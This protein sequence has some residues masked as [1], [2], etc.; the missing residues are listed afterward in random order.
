MYVPFK[1]RVAY[2][3]Q[4]AWTQNTTF[5]DNITFGG[6]LN[7]SFYESVLKACAL[8]SDVETLPDGDQTVIGEK[9]GRVPADIIFMALHLFIAYSKYTYVRTYLSNIEEYARRCRV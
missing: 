2:V 6:A 4:E 7:I 5:R 9:V 3:P 8:V 1:G